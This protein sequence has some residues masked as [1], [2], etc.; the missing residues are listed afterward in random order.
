MT[1]KM[2]SILQ[3]FATASILGQ[4]PSSTRTMIYTGAMHYAMA[5]PLSGQVAQS[6]TRQ[7]T[8]KV[9]RKFFM[10]KNKKT[11]IFWGKLVCGSLGLAMLALPVQGL[12]GGSQVFI[13]K[14][15]SCHGTGK[16]AASINPANLASSQWKNYFKR[17]K[18]KRKKD[19]S[20]IVSDA[21]MKVILQ[22]LV[23]NAAD[24]DHPEVAA[25]P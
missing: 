8:E 5:K 13:E 25:I 15:G 22:Y 6:V 14:C 20:G 10:G 2:V 4:P 23:D 3:F 21:E 7:N 1:E 24:S 16:E 11:K 17:C 18:H 9:R 19:I 12:A